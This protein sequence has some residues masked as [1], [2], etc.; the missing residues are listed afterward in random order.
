MNPQIRSL[1]KAQQN[2]KSKYKQ[3]KKS[4]DDIRAYGDSIQLSL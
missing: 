3:Y 2:G 4:P 1:K